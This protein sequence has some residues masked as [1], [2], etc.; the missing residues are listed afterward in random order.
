MSTIVCQ[1]C[2][3]NTFTELTGSTE[4]LF[5]NRG[6]FLDA[7]QKCTRCPDGSS[8]DEPGAST[9]ETLTLNEGYWRIS[10]SSEILVE[11]ELK[12][13]CV[14]G[15]SSRQTSGIRRL[16]NAVDAFSDGYCDTGHTGPLCSACSS[17]FFL[18]V[19][20]GKCNRCGDGQAEANLFSSWPLVFLCKPAGTFTL[21]ETVSRLLFL[22][23]CLLS[24][25]V[26]IF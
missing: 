7:Y 19:S 14:G 9:V 1:Q 11:C 3:G 16:L 2:P 8:C 23:V 5:C 20:T 6:Y 10:W 17:S 4:C 22:N 18:D 21:L 26:C 13:A 15:R 24:S 12:G 25:F